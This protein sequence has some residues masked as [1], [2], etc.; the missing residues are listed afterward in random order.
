[1]DLPVLLHAK[2]KKLNSIIYYLHT[3][4]FLGP[5]Q[6]ILGY[7]DTDLITA[8]HVRLAESKF[9]IA[10]YFY[11]FRFLAPGLIILNFLYHSWLNR[12]IRG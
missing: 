6:L 5:R 9:S 3:P 8:K 2:A 1:M 11:I 10:N 12:T 4:R 7:I